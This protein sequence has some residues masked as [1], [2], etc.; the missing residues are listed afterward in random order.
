MTDQDVVAPAPKAKRKKA[1]P[2][3][4]P[5]G[6]QALPP[7]P[8]PQPYL[9]RAPKPI[10]SFSSTRLDAQLPTSSHLVL[11]SSYRRP[12]TAQGTIS[13]GDAG[14]S[15]ARNRDR[16]REQRFANGLLAPPAIRAGANTSHRNRPVSPSGAAGAPTPAAAAPAPTAGRRRQMERNQAI[17]G[18]GAGNPSMTSLGHLGRILE[19]DPTVAA[20]PEERI[21]GTGQAQG[22]GQGVTAP[23]TRRRRRIVRGDEDS[24]GVSRRLTVTSREEGR[25]IGLARGASM[26]RL[27]VW[28]GELLPPFHLHT[29]A[30]CT[31][32]N[33]KEHTNA[34][35][36]PTRE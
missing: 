31:V 36:R 11:P 24:P 1:R 4:L 29:S 10:S 14:P 12:A 16:D 23:N 6:S 35:G 15:T 18:L 21:S 7:R 20:I 9:A 33:R 13:T 26:R 2:S 30:T 5:S 8:I 3:A 17:R 28:D 34:F 19:A 27:N 25:A 32:G 22:Q